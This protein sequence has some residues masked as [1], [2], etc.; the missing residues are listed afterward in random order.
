MKYFAWDSEKNEKL[1]LERDIG[2]EDVIN[3]IEDD[4]ILEVQEH[5]NKGKYPNQKRLIIEIDNYVYMIPFV[6]DEEKY[7]LK[8]IIPSRK[9]TKKYLKERINK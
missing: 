1:K 8:T 9:L 7:F 4:K 5:P 2:F 3:A 6:V